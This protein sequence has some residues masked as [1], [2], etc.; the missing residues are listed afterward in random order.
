MLKSNWKLSETGH[1]AEHNNISKRLINLMDYG[2]YVVNG[3]WSF[4]INKAVEDS[5]IAKKEL[6]IPSGTYLIWNPVIFSCNVNS[7]PNAIFRVKSSSCFVQIGNGTDLLV[8]AK[9]TLPQLHNDAQKWYDTNIVGN[10]IG[11]KMIGLINCQIEFINTVGFSNGIIWTSIDG[12][13]SQCNQV[14]LGCIRV[15]G[16]G[17]SILPV[18]SWISENYYTFNSISGGAWE[19][20][21]PGT[22]MLKLLKDP[23]YGSGASLFMGGSLESSWAEYQLYSNQLNNIYLKLRYENNTSMKIFF[24]EESQCNWIIGGSSIW[25]AQITDLSGFG[26]MIITRSSDGATSIDGVDLEIKNPN[27]GIILKSPDKSRWK[28]SI[29]DNGELKPTKMI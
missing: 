27:K 15:C 28:I 14:N 2:S 6:I 29:D 8:N 1:V 13:P 17:F 7:S 4:A 11:F 10:D 21:I 19:E 16:I 9:M 3:D 26:N 12:L 5:I 20:T 25:I 18:D 23:K 24:G 22:C